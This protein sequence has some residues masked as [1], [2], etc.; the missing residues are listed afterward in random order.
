M[1][2]SIIDLLQTDDFYGK[3]RNINFAKGMYRIPRNW[4]EYKELVK[5]MWHG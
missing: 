5:R 2:K 3:D 1:I 4:K